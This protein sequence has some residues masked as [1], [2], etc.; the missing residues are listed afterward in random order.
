MGMTLP[1]DGRNKHST[2]LTFLGIGLVVLMLVSVW[3]WQLNPQPFYSR[4]VPIRV[5]LYNSQGKPYPGVYL[6]ST[7]I[8][9]CAYS[10]CAGTDDAM[11]RRS[12]RDGKIDSNVPFPGTFVLS[13]G[14]DANNKIIKR[15]VQILHANQLVKLIL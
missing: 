5:A 7:N 1:T 12:G 2:T 11:V 14:T 9:S 15:R 10:E 6:L 8:V 4:R 13:F 3:K